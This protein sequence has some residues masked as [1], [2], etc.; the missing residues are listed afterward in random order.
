MWN[1]LLGLM[2]SLLRALCSASCGHIQWGFVSLPTH[3]LAQERSPL[4]NAILIPYPEK[5]QD[6][7]N[8]P[9]KSWRRTAKINTKYLVSKK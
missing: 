1:G 6:F 9:Y 3:L 8:Q 2:A 4:R 7:A 5:L